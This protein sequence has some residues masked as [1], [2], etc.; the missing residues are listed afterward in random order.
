[1]AYILTED[2]IILSLQ[3]VSRDGVLKE[4]AEL[5]EK[6]CPWLSGEAVRQA[7]QQREKFGSTGLGKGVA[8]PHCHLP[9]LNWFEFFMARSIE[10]LSFGAYD[11]KPVHIFFLILA[12]EN[13]SLS[14]LKSLGQ[15]AR[16]F[17][18]PE[19]KKRLLKSRGAGEIIGI[20]NEAETY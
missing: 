8:M 14:Y 2:R 15:L 4:L 17:R 7:L 3:A 6:T 18:D 19:I 20:I 10:G 13:H 5:A 12:P 16:F 9:S 1:M 11:G